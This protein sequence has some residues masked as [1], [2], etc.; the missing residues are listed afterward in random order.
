[1]SA[2]RRSRCDGLAHCILVVVWRIWPAG[3]IGTLCGRDK[4][5]SR[6]NPL[7]RVLADLESFRLTRWA[8]SSSIS[9]VGH[10]IVEDAMVWRKPRIIEIAV[11]LEINSY[12]CARVK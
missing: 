12:A 1:F 8:R 6:G 9:G 7:R 11:G 4:F 5:V 10:S 2:H 3:C